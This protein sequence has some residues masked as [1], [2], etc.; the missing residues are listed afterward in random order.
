M[1]IKL[2]EEYNKLLARRKM[3][4][5]Y[6]DDE[7]IDNEEKLKFIELFKALTSQLYTIFQEIEKQNIEFTD[8]EI[9]EGFHIE[10]RIAR[11][12]KYKH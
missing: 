3:A 1:N 11:F 10:F 12:K 6:L 2:L 8:N 9:K 4:V 7:K 5:I